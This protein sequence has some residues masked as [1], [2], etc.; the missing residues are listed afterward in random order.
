MQTETNAA[1]VHPVP[2][3][4]VL[5]PLRALTDDTRLQILE[6]LAAG[7]SLR[8]QELIDE[9]D[10]TQSTVSRHLKQL[11]AAGFVKE[12]R[13]DGANKNY[14]L[15]RE[16]LDELFALLSQLLSAE[17]AQTVLSDV[18]RKLPEHLHRFLDRDGL[19]VQWPRTSGDQKNLLD[20]LVE[21]FQPNQL[22]TEAEVNEL[23]SRWHTFDDPAILR[24]EMVDYGYMGRTS[25]GDR[26]WREK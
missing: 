10:V 6:M 13:G 5:F 14:R 4:Q 3:G 23:L 15:Y 7:E 17:N 21:K 8:A 2:R 12:E 24:R 18:R 20:Y 19:V 11:T 1:R 9:L 26:Y 22:Y 25:S 16:R